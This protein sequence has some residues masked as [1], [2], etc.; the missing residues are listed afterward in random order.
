M[1]LLYY[2]SVP[3]LIIDPKFIN[4]WAGIGNDTRKILEAFNSIFS[5]RTD[6][7]FDQLSPLGGR[8]RKVRDFATSTFYK[9][10]TLKPKTSDDLVFIPHISGAVPSRGANAIW[11]IHDLFP[12]TNP[13]W[14]TAR[15]VR[16]FLKTFRNIDFENNFFLC[17]SQTTLS[18]LSQLTSIKEKNLAV[19]LCEPNQ[20]DLMKCGNCEGCE[21]KFSSV[22]YLLNVNTIEPRK[23]IS[24]L[25]DIWRRLGITH[26]EFNLL[27]VGKYGWKVSEYEMKNLMQNSFGI[28]HLK[29]VCDG[30]L[31]NLFEGASGYISA[32]LSEGFN[33]P[34]EKARICNLPLLLSDIPVHRELYESLGTYFFDFS[35]GDILQHKIIEVFSGNS[36][37]G[38]PV[39]ERLG[40]E[41]AL[42]QALK[43]WKLLG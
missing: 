3:N 27:I 34:A 23:N 12:L 13:E 30:S 32:S 29:N 19:V 8:S 42:T 25:I 26:P 11:R 7:F 2:Q 38:A 1:S 5:S 36:M 16:L 37:S 33:I 31:N 6:A 43:K 17:N 35:S 14:F 15:G 28:T 39:H 9:P 18:V 4:H 24:Y 41:V 40:L 20:S 10:I 21:F 22:K